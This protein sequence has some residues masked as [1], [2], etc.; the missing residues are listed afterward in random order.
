MTL[1]ETSEDMVMT[2]YDETYRE[3]VDRGL[4]DEVAH[5][6]GETA[7]AMCL[8]ACLGIED[9]Q[10]REYIRTMNIRKLMDEF[11]H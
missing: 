4:D 2:A 10:A 7:A 6:E 3:A 5:A 1:D 11:F 8:A 9:E